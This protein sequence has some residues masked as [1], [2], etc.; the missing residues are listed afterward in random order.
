[1][2]TMAM[3]IIKM[4]RNKKIPRRIF[5]WR[6]ILTL[7]SKEKGIEMTKRQGQNPRGLLID[8]LTEHVGRDIYS[9]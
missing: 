6:L 4:L 1:M 8:R 3:M 7:Q 2:Q 5:C 9:I